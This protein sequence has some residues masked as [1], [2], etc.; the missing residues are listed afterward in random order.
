[1]SDEPIHEPARPP[2]PP[3]GEV[4]WA[5]PAMV[6]AML[7]IAAQWGPR[8]PRPPEAGPAPGVEPVEMPRHA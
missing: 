3:A 2:A 4:Y 8:A 7:A 1:M 5:R 6:A